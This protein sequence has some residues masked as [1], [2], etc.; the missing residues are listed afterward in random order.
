MRM[1]VRRITVMIFARMAQ[2]K[3]GRHIGSGGFGTVEEAARI[4]SDGSVLEDRLAQKK[5]LPKWQDDAEAL[6]RFRRE[7]RILSEMDHPHIL[8]VVGRNLSARPPWFI[9]PRAETNLL[10][11]IEEGR[12]DERWMT[13]SFAAVL[14]GMTYAHSQR[15]IH[16]D[17]KPENVLIVGGTPMIADFG[18]GKRLDPDATDLTQTDVGMGTLAYM[19]PEQ[20]LDAAHVGP[21]ADVY[22]LGKLLVHM[23]TGDTPLV[24]RPRVEDIPER[25]RS[26]VEKCTADHA[27]DRYANAADALAAFRLLIEGAN[28]HAHGAERTTSLESLIARWEETPADGDGLIVEEI[29]ALFVN[30]RENEELFWQAFPR[31]PDQLVEQMLADQPGQFDLILRA[32]NE[33]IEGSLPFEYCDVVAN[34]YRRVYRL[35]QDSGHKRMMLKRLIE[36][37]P[38]H[39]RRHVGDVVASLLQD[40]Q[41]PAEVEMATAVIRERPISAL[42]FEPYV[43]NRQ[44]ASPIA[45]A[46]RFARPNA[47]DDV[48]S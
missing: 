40:M 32:Y 43:R 27:D 11:E 36:L 25:F 14:S 17:L 47:D 26:F 30:E 45:K 46:F 37:G 35:T 18:L 6:A 3:I 12:S 2:F 33:H 13:R 44:L 15:R 28:E 8:P 41:E 48:P 39:N 7:V 29:A 21:P 5:L 34:L 1:N 31:L 23:I 10:A 22:A 4:D 24:G 9:M 20:F 38:N 19:A 42:W 16:R